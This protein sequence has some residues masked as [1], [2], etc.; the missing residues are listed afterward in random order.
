MVILRVG[1]EITL[2][3]Y[4]IGNIFS[5]ITRILLQEKEFHITCTLSSVSVSKVKAIPS[6]IGE[7]KKFSHD[8]PLSLT[9][10][11]GVICLAARTLNCIFML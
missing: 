3:I 4:T 6:R 9:N 10:V 11:I 7:L 8:M 2:L 5:S 1:M